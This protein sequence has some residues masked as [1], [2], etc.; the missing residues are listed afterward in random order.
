MNMHK[1]IRLTPYD[2]QKIWEL[3]QTNEHKV[4]HLAVVFRVS[5]PT[6]YKVLARA[7]TQDFMPRKSTNDRYR[8]L[9]YGLKRLAKSQALEYS[10]PHIQDSS[11]SCTPS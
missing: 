9:K 4:S 6:I 5:R 8:S 11:L 10:G 7:R 1:R 3:W 2:R